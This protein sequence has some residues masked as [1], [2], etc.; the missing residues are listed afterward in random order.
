[1]LL[2]TINF[3]LRGSIREEDDTSF[4]ADFRALIFQNSSNKQVVCDLNIVAE[5]SVQN[6]LSDFST[7][8]SEC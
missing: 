3:E 4:L 1:M 5:E 8:I 6:S 7:T 2:I